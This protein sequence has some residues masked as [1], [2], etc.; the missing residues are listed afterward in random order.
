MSF[1]KNV[2]SHVFLKSEKNEKYVLS[3][4]G[5]GVQKI[6]TSEPK[7][8]CRKKLFLFMIANT[9]IAYHFT[10]GPVRPPLTEV[11]FIALLPGD[12]QNPI[13]PL[14]RCI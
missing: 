4:T 13:T 9:V 1:L 12:A 3:N 11:H 7:L 14:L 10:F 5:E 8:A 6:P 2:K